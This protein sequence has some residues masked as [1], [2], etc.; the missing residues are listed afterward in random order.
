MVNIDPTNASSSLYDPWTSDS[1]DER[2][3]TATRSGPQP[4][5]RDVSELYDLPDANG[6]LLGRAAQALAP[7][8]APPRMLPATGL[9]SADVAVVDSGLGVTPQVEAG[10]DAFRKAATAT[11]HVP[12][13]GDVVVAARFR[14]AHGSPSV[15]A[16]RTNELVAAGASVGVPATRVAA[17]QMGRGTPEEVRKLTQT[18]LRRG[19]LPAPQVGGEQATRRVQRLM[20]SYGIGIDCAGYVQQAFTAA[21]GV[22]RAQAGFAPQAA[23][24]GL[25]DPS[26][27]GPFRAVRP[28]QAQAG[29]VMVLRAPDGQKF[30]H[31]LLVFDRHDLRP[32]EAKSFAARSPTDVARMWTGRISVFVVD[33]SFGSGGNP[34]LG[35]VMRQKWI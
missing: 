33:S 8:A 21:H 35:G 5:T 7:S 20:T 24:E 12:G 14:I 25:F 26:A 28:E 2:R 11:Y 22:T 10:M 34:D 29:D 16:E 4:P 17:V 6:A 30:G 13:E 15:P 31:R 32:D 1:D 9:S 23:D 27:T 3:K 18:L 19:K